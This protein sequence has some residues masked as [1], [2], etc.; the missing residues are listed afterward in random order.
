MIIV[1]WK[2]KVGNGVGHLLSVMNIQHSIMDDQDLDDAILADA[3][4]I[5][6]SPGVKQSHH[7]YQSYS[8]KI[9]SELQFLSGLLPSIGLKNTTWIG[10][11]ATNGKSTTTWVTY[12]VLKEMFPQK[13][14]WITGN[15]DIPV[16]ETLAQIIEQKK[17]D[18]DHI[19]VVECSSFMLYGLRDFVFDYSILLN[20]A[21]D[22][23]DWH[24]DFDEYQESKLTLLR[25][26]RDAFFV[27]ASSWSLLDKLLSNRGTKV[28]ESF[29]LGPT[30]FLGAHNKINLAAVE[31][32]TLQYCKA[33]WW[34][35][36]VA[37][38]RFIEVIAWIHPL[39]HRLGLI[40]EIDGVKIYDDGICT[41]SHSLS[42]ALSS[43]D[44]KCVLI[45]WWYDKGDDYSWLSELFLSKVWYAVLMWQTAEKLIKVCWQAQVPYIV[46]SSLQDAVKTAV[47]QAKKL[48]L[49]HVI[50][51]P[52]A[53]SFDMFKNVYDRVDQFEKIVNSL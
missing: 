40:R 36:Q 48:A 7:I 52:W 35:P 33:C 25:R 12:H 14:V 19:F 50:F 37:Q 53:A 24:K 21:R 8:H 44:Q 41:S 49:S 42:A 31:A 27:P 30:K 1:F 16:S 11:T 22:H 23:L 32:L 46:V 3:D 9:Q 29:D 17:Q 28:E 20:V 45:A 4:V 38:S 26:T 51:S 13:N 47:E 5:L 18:E 39:P 2:G 10:I 6:V 34:N 43:F 15:F